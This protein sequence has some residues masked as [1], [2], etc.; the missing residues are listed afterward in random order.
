MTEHSTTT[1]AE[2]D[3]LLR[4]LFMLLMAFFYQ[5][6]GTFLFFVTIIQ[7]VIVLINGMPNT[8]LV[9]FGRSLGSYIKQ[10]VSYL[11]FASDERPFPFS[12]WPSGD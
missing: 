5:L 9:S 2:R 6:A 7:F 1:S 12:D 11:T 8:R 4:G 3:T 10:I